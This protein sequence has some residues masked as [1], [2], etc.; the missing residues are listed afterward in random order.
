MDFY[1]KVSRLCIDVI[2]TK[3][4]N[5]YYYIFQKNNLFCMCFRGVSVSLSVM[6]LIPSQAGVGKLWILLMKRCRHRV[7]NAL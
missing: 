3:K 5:K 4:Y 7:P 1:D 6:A 2:S